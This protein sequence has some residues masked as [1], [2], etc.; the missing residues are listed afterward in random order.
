LNLVSLSASGDD[1]AKSSSKVL[2]ET[3][4]VKT[5]RIFVSSTFKDMKLEREQ[6][7]KQV[8]PE[9][10]QLCTERNVFF[11]YVDLRWG[12]TE[13]ESSDGQT[14]NLC[15]SEIDKCQPYFICFLGERYG[16]SQSSG[17]IIRSHR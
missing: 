17:T 5:I 7:V 8:F 15:L 4:E 11:T 16:W 2:K 1:L 12:I 9:L 10:K 13:E 3:Q 6:L 14:L